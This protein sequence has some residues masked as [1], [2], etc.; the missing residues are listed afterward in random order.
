MDLVS[1]LLLIVLVDF[2][3]LCTG[4]QLRQLPRPVLGLRRI[5]AAHKLTWRAECL[6]IDI[7]NKVV[8]GGRKR[9]F[10]SL[11]QR[12]AVVVGSARDQHLLM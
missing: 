12:N 1:V 7:F 2:L 4:Q 9:H 6:Q 8:N 10:I 5:I 11:L 3:Q